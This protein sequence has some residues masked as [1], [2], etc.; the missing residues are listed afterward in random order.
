MASHCSSDR[1]LRERNV[2]GVSHVTTDPPT[3][4][5]TQMHGHRC[6]TVSDTQ[7]GMIMT[8]ATSSQMLTRPHARTIYKRYFSR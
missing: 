6:F 5:V 8:F 4:F 3:S 2:C 7:S 1:Q